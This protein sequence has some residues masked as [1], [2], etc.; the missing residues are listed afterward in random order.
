VSARRQRAQ[1]LYS[2]RFRANSLGHYAVFYDAPQLINTEPEKYGQVTKADL[3]RVARTYL[4]DSNRT[5]VTT[6]PKAA[7]AKTAPGTR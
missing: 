5:V 1:Q 4:K 6:L 2:T 7:A 3:Q